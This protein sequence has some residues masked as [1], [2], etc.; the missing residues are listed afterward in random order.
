MPGD[1]LIDWTHMD[2]VWKN[3]YRILKTSFGE[4]SSNLNLISNRNLWM[5]V[6]QKLDNTG[7]EAIT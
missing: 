2:R 6:P 3:H 7:T 1:I 5:Q 4:M